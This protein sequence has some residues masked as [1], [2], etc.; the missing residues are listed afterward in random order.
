MEEEVDE[1]QNKADIYKNKTKYAIKQAV[2][3][4]SDKTSHGN[5]NEQDNDVAPQ[6][7]LLSLFIAASANLPHFMAHLRKLAS[8]WLIGKTA[9]KAI[10]SPN[11]MNHANYERGRVG[12]ANAVGG[13]ASIELV[14]PGR[15]WQQ[16]QQQQQQ[17]TDW[18]AL[19]EAT[20][21]PTKIVFRSHCFQ[22]DIYKSIGNIY[23]EL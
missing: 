7:L 18:V 10:K 11:W 20:P 15:Q 13:V 1:V 16:L 14:M 5:D 23:R 21:P 4:H 22:L 8:R 9:Y 6:P 12:Q 2:Q 17:H 3:R 19:W